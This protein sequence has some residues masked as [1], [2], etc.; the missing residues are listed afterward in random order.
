MPIDKNIKY[1]RQI[2]LWANTGQDRLES[3]SVCIIGASAT[4]SEVIKNL[5]LPGIGEF[6]LVDSRLVSEDDLSGNFFLQEEDLG[7]SI[8]LA[9]CANLLELNPD[10]SGYA[11]TQP[12]LDLCAER[13]FW[14]QFNAV[15]VCDHIEDLVLST[16]KKVLWNQNIPLLIVATV[17]FYGILHIVSKETTIVETH[18]PSKLFDLRIDC[19]WPELQ[20]YSDSFVLKELDSTEHAHVPYIVIFIKALLQWKKNHE[21][22]AP[23]NFS[24]KKE[25]R[26]K[27][28]EGLALNLSMEA[29]FLEASQS[30]HR[31]LQVTKIPNTIEELFN[32]PELNFLTADSPLFWVYVAALKDF[33]AENQHQLPL[34]GNL[35]DMTSKTSN[36]VKLHNIYRKKAAEDSQLF[37]RKLSEKLVQTGRSEEDINQDMIASFCK[38]AS[39]LYVSNG[40]LHP[41]SENLLK[42][43]KAALETDAEQNLLVAYF[44]IL[45]LHKCHKSKTAENFG[46]YVESFKDIYSLEEVPKHACNTLKELFLHNTSN[47]HNICSFMGGIV[48]QE[49]LKILTQQYIP[50][51]NLFI[52]NGV[53]STSEKWKI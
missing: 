25:F 26:E 9:V 31:A 50:L 15:I 47:Y 35:P 13:N 53:N 8:A 38:N 37:L 23:Q 4:G 45:A 19:P 10:V 36:Y 2:R 6:T 48:G 1:D 14:S 43:L 16:L 27:Y 39:F 12:V 17:G 7:T 21:G 44:G 42:E 46:S 34:P 11:I 29:N 51:D 24:E 20:A 33:V 18:D 49:V 52:F 32:A 5:V 30:I 40:N 41:Y 22:H 28:V 3:S